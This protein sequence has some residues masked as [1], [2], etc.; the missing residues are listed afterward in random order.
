MNATKLTCQDCGESFAPD[1]ADTDA[2][3]YCPKCNGHLEVAAPFLLGTW[4]D[5]IPA[6]SENDP[7]SLRKYAVIVYA[8]QA[9][10]LVTGLTALAAIVI[11]YVKIKDVRR[12]W[13][14]S[15]FKWQIR[16]FWFA[17]LWC[18]LGL[19]T[20]VILIGIPVLLVALIWGIYRIVK[21]WLRLMNNRPMY[22]A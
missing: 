17:L 10:S 7:A 15:H 22:S 12:T 11:N 1:E 13:L 8:L 4:G 20:S 19:A 3:M 16:T 6:P 2:Y 21:G 18:I 5:G 14:E 9:A